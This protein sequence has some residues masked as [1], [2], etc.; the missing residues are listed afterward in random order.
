ME[1]RG[2]LAGLKIVF[3]GDGNNVA[4]SIAELAGHL[5]MHFTLACPKGYEQPAAIVKDF[6]P[7]FQKS[8]AK[9]AVTNDP[10]EAVVGADCIY[11]DVWISMGEEAQA[12]EKKRHFAGFQVNAALLARAPVECLVTHCLP[13]HPGEEITQEVMDLPR[14][15]I[16]DEAE[17]RLHA[18]K[19]VLL[20]LIGSGYPGAKAG[21]RN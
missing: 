16:F 11:T 21:R 20:T 12:E 13:A 6:L 7:L 3:V 1:R 4:N 2:K 19:A 5:G 17:N 15:V 18:Q 10:A 14:C 9:Y 8:G